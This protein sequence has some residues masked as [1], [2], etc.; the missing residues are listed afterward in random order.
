DNNIQSTNNDLSAID[1][2]S[3]LIELL[4]FKKEKKNPA[5]ENMQ[6]INVNDYFRQQDE[7]RNNIS[8]KKSA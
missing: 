4:G 5:Y 7:A 3:L 8:Q 2:F 6:I 1:K